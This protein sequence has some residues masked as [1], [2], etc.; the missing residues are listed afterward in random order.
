MFHSEGNLHASLRTE[1]VEHDDR[2]YN[3]LKRQAQGGVPGFLQ[4]SKAVL[5]ALQGWVNLFPE[6]RNIFRDW[7]KIFLSWV[8]PKGLRDP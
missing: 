8:Y 4:R 1:G 2:S 3:S 7:E 5:R 6:W